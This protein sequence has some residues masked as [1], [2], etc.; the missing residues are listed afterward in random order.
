MP[1]QSP[2]VTYVVC[3]VEQREVKKVHDLLF[4]ESTLPPEIYAVFF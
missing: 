3:E 1:R 2:E 4:S